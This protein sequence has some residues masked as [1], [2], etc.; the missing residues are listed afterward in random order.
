MGERERVDASVMNEYEDPRPAIGPLS[1]RRVVLLHSPDID[2]VEV[3]AGDQLNNAIRDFGAETELRYAT[4][5]GRV[6]RS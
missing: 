1:L 2:H 6:A 3:S 5:V 4:L